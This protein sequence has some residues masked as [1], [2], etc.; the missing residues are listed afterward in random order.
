MSPSD[1]IVVAHIGVNGMGRNHIRW[2]AGLEDV[3]VAALCDV[4]G[5]HL[6]KAMETLYDIRPGSRT[7]A[8][9]D[10]RR[11]L[12]RKDIDAITCATPDHWHALVAVMAFQ[13]GKDVYGEKPLTYSAQEGRAMLD[14]LERQPDDGDPHSREFVEIPVTGPREVERAMMWLRRACRL[15]RTAAGPV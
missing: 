10:F 12:D 1:K 2:F 9:L 3:E 8:Y 13:S 6:G 4:D 5:G 11:V 15:G 14:T 7:E